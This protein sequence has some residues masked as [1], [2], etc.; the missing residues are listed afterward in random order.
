MESQLPLVGVSHGLLP[1]RWESRCSGEVPWVSSQSSRVCALLA[2]CSESLVLIFTTWCAPHYDQPSSVREVG[3][4]QPYLPCLGL[5]QCMILVHGTSIE[6]TS[7]VLL[8][9]QLM[10]GKMTQKT[11]TEAERTGRETDIWK[12]RIFLEKE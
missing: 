2:H 6:L 9:A 3:Q 12:K 10:A 5:S 7:A 11:K 1:K 8:E 4:H